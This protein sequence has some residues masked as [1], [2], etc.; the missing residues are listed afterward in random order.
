MLLPIRLDSQFQGFL[1]LQ[2]TMD[3]CVD[4]HLASS[5]PQPDEVDLTLLTFM[6]ASSSAPSALRALSLDSLCMR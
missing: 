5:V 4:H 3:P 6:D 1:S 2:A